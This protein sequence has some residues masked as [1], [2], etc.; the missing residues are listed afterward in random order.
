MMKSLTQKSSSKG[1][2]ER[3][4]APIPVECFSQPNNILPIFANPII[5][6]DT[7]RPST[8]YFDLNFIDAPTPRDPMV[9]LVFQNYYTASITI[10]QA[11]SLSST[12]SS[13]GGG[14]GGGGATIFVPILE[15]KVLMSDPYSEGEAQKWVTIYASEFNQHYVKG[16][17]LRISLVQ[18]ACS[19]ILFEIKN[20][21]ALSKLPVGDGSKGKAIVSNSE[22]A[23]GGSPLPRSPSSSAIKAASACGTTTSSSS[24]AAATITAS[25]N[26]SS[27]TEAAAAL[28]PSFSSSAIGDLNFLRDIAARESS[29]A[30]DQAAALASGEYLLGK[31][32]ESRKKKKAGTSSGGAKKVIASAEREKDDKDGDPY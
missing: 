21:C 17:S 24:S 16:K 28:V 13:P 25:S 11:L 22:Y 29:T 30:N 8:C 26:T 19:W 6:R 18:P 14:G 9:A 23:E 15:N 20:C 12:P 4:V 27:T 10:S 5:R 2:V 7:A 1:G 32:K 3:V 31:R